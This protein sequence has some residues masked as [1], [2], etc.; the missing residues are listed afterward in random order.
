MTK[1]GLILE[2]GA[3]RGLFSAGAVDLMMQNGIEFDGV[4]G[5]SAG[6]AFGC[7]VK[8]GQIGRSIR[9]N[10]Q[11]SKNPA[12]SSFRSLLKTGDLYNAEYCYH[13]LPENID[14]FDKESFEKSPVEFYVVCTDVHT[15][16][17]VYHRVD[18]ADYEGMEWIR[19]S[20]SMPVVSRT[21]P[22]DGKEL[23][24][25]GISDSIPLR[26]FESIGYDHNVV[27][28][29][30][31]L[32]YR[33][34]PANPLLL[35]LMRQYPAMAEAMAH[36]HE[37]YNETLEYI[38][39]KEKNGDLFVIRPPEPLAVGKIEHSVAKMQE[40]YQT[41]RRTMEAQLDALKAY[42]AK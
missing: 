31:P 10:T 25:G 37:V 39:E 14:P 28:L 2:G 34:A 33:K 27:V 7:N 20:A 15:G 9:Y 8:S 3:M 24:D 6:A 16:E 36:R 40:A 29:T 19:A 35:K 11:Q 38:L 17:P 5:V 4:I 32:E 23:M 13:T 30:R 22:L 18:K 41:G 42:L 21:V 12:Y 1:K 26:Y